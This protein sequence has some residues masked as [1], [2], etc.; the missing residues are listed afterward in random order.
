MASQKSTAAQASSRGDAQAAS[1]ATPL[2]PK[3]ERGRLRVAAILDAA[4]QVFVERG[5][6]AA[7]M[8]EIAARSSTA[9]GS[10]YRF[11]PTKEVLADALLARYAEMLREGLEA[12]A[13]RAGAMS[14]DEL[15]DTFVEMMLAFRPGRAAAMV[16]LE[17]RS[18]A[19]GLREAIRAEMRGRIAVMLAAAAGID[20]AR[21]EAMAIVLLHV[22]KFVPMA[23]QSGEAEAEVLLAEARALVGLYVHRAFGPE[24]RHPQDCSPSV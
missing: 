14:A 10:L 23:E 21:A 11:F 3:R 20:Q 24:D 5:F 16:L 7:T 12:R 2:E 19:Q 9:I 6:D 4:A 17:S 8:S 13:A 18:D 22:L 1:P 15:A